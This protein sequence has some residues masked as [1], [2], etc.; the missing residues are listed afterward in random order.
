MVCSVHSPEFP[1]VR[2]VV[3]KI[4][5]YNSA[6]SIKW[7]S[8]AN[9]EVQWG[10]VKRHYDIDNLMW[11]LYRVVCSVVY[12]D[13]TPIRFSIR[14]ARERRG[15]VWFY[16]PCSFDTGSARISAFSFDEGQATAFSSVAIGNRSMK[17][18]SSCHL[19][20]TICRLHLC[21][22]SAFHDV[23]QQLSS[24][25]NNKRPIVLCILPSIPLF[26]LARKDRLFIQNFEIIHAG[27]AYRWLAYLISAE[28]PAPSYKPFPVLLTC[29]NTA[30]QISLSFFFRWG[31]R[32]WTKSSNPSSW[33]GYDRRTEDRTSR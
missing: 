14:L 27:H 20:Y 6:M 7:Y 23:L 10:Q 9:W 15:H 18:V 17:I 3:P 16:K 22:L 13:C 4:T 30:L 12:N 26:L 11:W 19:M 21:F 25:N 33:R 5:I 2:L 31:W 29:I 32:R 1:Y 28:K 8:L 24:S